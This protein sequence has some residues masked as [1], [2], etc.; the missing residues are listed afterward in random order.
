MDKI[1]SH[2]KVTFANEPGVDQ[3]GL[4]FFHSP[5]LFKFESKHQ[6][7][8]PQLTELFSMYFEDIFSE[9]N[10]CGLFETQAA[11]SF[12]GEQ[13]RG[14]AGSAYTTV[15]PSAQVIITTTPTTSTL[16]TVI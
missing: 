14:S 6:I 11:G 4:V 5:S 10:P 2:L 15:L 3:G 1:K 7:L 16:Y 9:S 8:L 12:E 13:R